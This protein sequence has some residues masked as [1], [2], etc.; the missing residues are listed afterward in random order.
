MD[1][2]DTALFKSNQMIVITAHNQEKQL[3]M[4]QKVKLAYEKIPGKITDPK[5][6]G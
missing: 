5:V 4:F 6:P 1:G 3:E 2:L